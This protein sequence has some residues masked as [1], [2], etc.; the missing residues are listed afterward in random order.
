MTRNYARMY[1]KTMQIPM[2]SSI[3]A[4]L[5]HRKNAFSSF[6]ISVNGRI[7]PIFMRVYSQMS[8]RNVGVREETIRHPII[9]RNITIVGSGR[10]QIGP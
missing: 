4:M 9:P 10:A 1:S 8:P 3:L 7:L 6:R 5:L 2:V